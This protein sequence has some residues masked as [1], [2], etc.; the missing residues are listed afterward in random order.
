M[1]I[2]RRHASGGAGTARDVHPSSEAAVD[3]NLAKASRSDRSTGRPITTG[4]RNS[5]P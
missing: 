3:T 2:L 4:N 1:E 5:I